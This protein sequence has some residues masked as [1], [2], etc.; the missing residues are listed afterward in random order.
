MSRMDGGIGV[1]AASLIESEMQRET[2]MTQAIAYS[3]TV[4]LRACA[5]RLNGRMRML[6]ACALRQELWL[7]LPI[8]LIL[9]LFAVGCPD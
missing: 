7:V 6:L 9:H 3:S 5:L 1:G 4:P 2:A 8:L